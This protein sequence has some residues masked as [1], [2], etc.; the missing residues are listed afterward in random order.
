MGPLVGLIMLVGCATPGN[1]APGSDPIATET[2][3]A[4][5]T[6]ALA[7]G[8]A[9]ADCPAPAG[10][11]WQEQA[12]ASPIRL[13]ET[14]DGLTVD[15]V[16]YPLPDY[17]GKPW[18]QWG[19][20]VVMGDGKFISAVGDHHGPDGNSFFYAY[21][22]AAATVTRFADVL[23]LVDH[24]NGGFGY[25]KVHAQ[26]VPGPCGEVYAHTYW[27]TRRNLKYDDN[28][29]GDVLI[30]ID[31]GSIDVVGVPAEGRGTASMA[32]SADGSLLYL[33]AVEPLE[34]NPA[35]VIYDVQA[36]RQVASLTDYHTGNRALAVDNSDRVYFSAGE[37]R[38]S[39]YDPV[40]GDVSDSGASLPGDFLRAATPARPDGSFVGVTRRPAEFFVLEPGGDTRSLGSAAGYTASLAMSADGNHVYYVPGAHGS[41]GDMGTPVIDLDPETGQQ[42][43]LVE[44][45]EAA[46]ET[47]GVRLGG[48]YNVVLDPGQRRLYVGLN[49]GEGDETFGRVFL[50]IINLP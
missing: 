31:P 36:R 37:S 6:T 3:I 22:P 23:S 11:P 35:L 39:L 28:Y 29:R 12:T 46:A 32:G 21:D 20:G 38:L 15:I 48:S 9:S 17:E 43:T 30:R 14:N 25:G 10:T 16:E 40:T 49:A 5:G 8:V 4:T 34:K 26:M 47:L 2:T 45:F 27:G 44:L 13:L 50:A 24:E 41:S 42:R 1:P 7:T 33:E 18:S 19:Q